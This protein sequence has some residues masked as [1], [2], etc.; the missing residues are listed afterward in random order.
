[1]TERTSVDKIRDALVALAATIA[2][3]V[4]LAAAGFIF[5]PFESLAVLALGVAFFVALRFRARRRGGRA[6]EP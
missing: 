6:S 2:L 5:G 1:M 3:F 4:V